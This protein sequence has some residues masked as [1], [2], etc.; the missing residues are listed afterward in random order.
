MR[1]GGHHFMK[2]FHKIP[3][4]FNDGF[5]NVENIYAREILKYFSDIHTPH[6]NSR[7]LCDIL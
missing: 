2:S 7:F 6:E 1:G 4:F 3:F 5:P